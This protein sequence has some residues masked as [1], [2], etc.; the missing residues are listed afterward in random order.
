MEPETI[1]VVDDDEHMGFTFKEVM[2]S[3]G[4]RVV[5]AR[6]G[7]EALERVKADHLDLVL[8][9]VRMPKMDGI[10]AL[11]QM[12][13][14][15]PDL[16]VIMVTAFGSKDI[17]V[18]ALK[19]GAY[20]YF[21]KPVDI[22]EIRI[23]VRRVLEKAKLQQEVD[24]LR[25]LVA[26]NQPFGGI[27][28]TSAPMMEVFNLVRSIADSNVE[29]LICGESGTG[30]EL[31]AKAIHQNGSRLEKPFVKINCAAIPETLLESE[32]FGY[33]KGAFTGATHGKPGKFEMAHEGT[34]LLDEIGDMSLS[35]QAKVL[36][37]IQEKEL[38]RLGSTSTTSVDVRILA[39][40]NKDLPEAISSGQFREDLFYRLNVITMHLPPLRDRREDI[41]L[42]MEH[43]IE[44][45]NQ[46]HNRRVSGISDSVAERFL[47][48]R[49]PGNVRE[50]E[51]VVQRALIL[52]KDTVI[53]IR[54]LPE[55]IAG[56]PL[57]GGNSE[58]PLL[59]SA[60]DGIA[61]QAEKK[62]IQEALEKVGGHR[63]K[64]AELLGISRK[65]LHNKMRKHGL[66]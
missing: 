44:K 10:E 9:D 50:L 62:M 49:W 23:V 3:E 56:D 27:V 64:T 32:L 61:D 40:T 21:T 60:V 45:F 37:V 41:L 19:L 59:L 33:E 1:L 46:I 16:P 6:D 53:G 28:G 5:M 2:T 52:T 35:T 65:T 8:M 36:R 20:D 17:A 43:F 30:K 54:D 25:R 58:N 39:S 47:S 7:L 15:V 38:E 48:Y 34:L 63:Q 4:Y 26:G 51:N 57:G 66:L 18:E 14:I 31:V 13:N 29:V 12:V 42:L 24:R 22:H 55:Q 11:K